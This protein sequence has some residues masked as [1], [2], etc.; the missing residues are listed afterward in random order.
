MVAI[1]KTGV[2]LHQSFHYNENKVRQGKA[3]CIGAENYPKDA[4]ELTL[5]DKI[6]RLTRQ[7]GLNEN[8][9]H[10]SVH[11][12]LN[13][14]ATERLSQLQ[15]QQ[16]AYAYMEGIGFGEQPYLVYEHYDAG[17]PHIHIVTTKVRANGSGI[18]MYNIGRN[19]SEKV[20]KEIEES[21]G[22]V[23]AQKSGQ[24]QTHQPEPVGAKRVQYGKTETK[25]AIGAVL[26]FVLKNYRYTSLPELNAVLNQYNV[27][28]DYGGENSRIYRNRGL[29]YQ[30][31]NGQGNKAGVPIQASDFAGKPTLA[32]LESC[33]TANHVAR[34]PHKQRV[35][36]AVDRAFLNRASVDLPALESA[37]EKQGI[38]ML[39]RQNRDR[40]IY[41]ITYVDHLTRC[42]FNGSALGKAYS[43]KGIL[44]RC[45]RKAEA[46]PENT[47]GRQF[48]QQD[49]SQAFVRLN[50]LKHDG[51]DTRPVSAT[52]EKEGTEN[53]ITTQV[54]D[55]LM[56]T[57][58][59]STYV[60]GELKK[61]LRKKKKKRISKQL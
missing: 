5:T 9:R 37:L 15:L 8:I 54:L 19:R 3:C 7:A 52:E 59:A 6:N 28:A 41:G 23:K 40:V 34:Q 32:F 1:I 43:A 55:A 44:E 57:E 11:I 49:K 13:F 26:K 45:G 56:R 14:D 31:L 18:D 30:A 25:K 20:R 38:R 21:F 53:P 22:L 60:P 24:K 46:I 17:H 33:F 50:H 39:T 27:V 61:R 35:K 48:P 47:A 10:K 2:S 29:V 51:V 16:I 4:T 36:A 58:Q 42:V 12:S